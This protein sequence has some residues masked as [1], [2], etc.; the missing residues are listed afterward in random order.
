MLQAYGMNIGVAS[1]WEANIIL[2]DASE[3]AENIFLIEFCN[4]TD[5]FRHDS[6]FTL[7]AY[8]NYYIVMFNGELCAAGR[9]KADATRFSFKEASGSIPKHYMEQ[10]LLLF[11]E[12][13][14]VKIPSILGGK[15][16]IA[17][18]VQ[19]A[20]PITL[21]H[22]NASTDASP[23]ETK[24]YTQKTSC[25][26]AS[27]TQADDDGWID[28]DDLNGSDENDALLEESCITEVKTADKIPV[29]EPISFKT[30]ISV[31][32]PTPIQQNVPHE[33]P[34][35]NEIFS[36]PS[37]EIDLVRDRLE[38][39]LQKL[40]EVRRTEYQLSDECNRLLDRCEQLQESIPRI[41]HLSENRAKLQKDL[42][43][44]TSQ[45]PSDALQAFDVELEMLE[46]MR[47]SLSVCN[48]YK[49]GVSATLQQTLTEGQQ[50]LSQ[51]EA[52]QSELTT[53]KEEIVLHREQANI[54]IEQLKPHL[55][56]NQRISAAL[57]GAQNVVD[58]LKKAKLLLEESDQLLAGLI[59]K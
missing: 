18:A 41:P 47:Q 52:L 16:S 55:D 37:P 28:E 33:S 30:D 45:F 2:N 39:H 12:Q 13:K 7:C 14:P 51:I 54:L 26:A 6:E 10:A 23:Q 36:T 58:L 3:S 56:A 25:N 24:S 48:G 22:C 15:L 8:N 50:V 1:S 20:T 40:L 17:G 34:I 11:A 27:S 29:E 53:K 5:P 59:R 31:I 42:E 43:K 38:G 49:D 46:K 21:I 19:D 44:L 9:G 57:P 32:S 35:L 4:A